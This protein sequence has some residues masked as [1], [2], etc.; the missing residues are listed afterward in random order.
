MFRLAPWRS[1][2]R[3]WSEASRQKSNRP[4]SSV[5]AIERDVD[6]ILDQVVSEG[7]F[8]E[9][10]HPN[11]TV[12]GNATLSFSGSSPEWTHRRNEDKSDD[13]ARNADLA[14]L[15]RHHRRHECSP[16]VATLYLPSFHPA[17]REDSP[18]R[19]GRKPSP[20]PL[21]Q[22]ILIY[23]AARIGYVQTNPASVAHGQS[24][25]RY[26]FPMQLLETLTRRGLMTDA[27]RARASDA[28]KAAPEFPPHQVL[29]DKGFLQGRSAAADPRPR[30]SAS[31]WSICRTPRSIRPYS[32]A[33]PQKLVH[34]KNLM[35][36]AAQQRHARR[37]HRRP[38][39]RLR[40]RRAADADRPAHPSGARQ[41]ARNHPAHQDAL[42]RRR[43][44]RRRPG[45]RSTR[46]RRY[47]APRRTSRPTT[48]RWPRRPR[49]RR[50]SSSS[51]RS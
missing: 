27:D 45:R 33:M 2:H 48:A 3:R 1:P 43:R 21:F 44:H 12:A 42:R 28:I 6:G 35:P 9:K 8:H 19:A 18:S 26:R 46:R 17:M 31:N 13:P 23:A 29:I 7:F 51:T 41:P 39:R 34:R 15:L 10:V 38:V 32:A 16:P 20:I 4:I 25:S 5:R 47:R 49:K 50:S 24:R 40:P 36:I 14:V 11:F 22:R 37:R 30:S